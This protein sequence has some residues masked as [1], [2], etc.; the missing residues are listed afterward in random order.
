MD[1][2][3]DGIQ[4]ALEAGQHN[5]ETHK[6]LSNWCE[7]AQVSR[8]RGIG[9]VE[10]ETGLPIG[11]MG[12]QCKYSKHTS[13]HSWLL[14]DSVYSFYKKCCSDC[15]NRA[16]VSMPNILKFVVPRLQEE[17]ERKKEKSELIE[18]KKK[19]QCERKLKRLEL[20]P[21]LSFEETFVLDL[22]DELDV[23]DLQSNDPRLEK[24]AHLRRF[25][26]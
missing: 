14:E 25:S 2:F 22:L 20:R 7:Y 13:M 21:N 16:P 9:M 11:H 5:A 6:L 24:F 15:D 23:D 26:R 1:N 12:M 19:A 17:E 4:K 8:S 18:L 10:A 3:D